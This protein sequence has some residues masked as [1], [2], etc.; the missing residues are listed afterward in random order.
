MEGNLLNEEFFKHVVM[1]QVNLVLNGLV[2]NLKKDLSENYY[3]DDRLLSR[4]EVAKKLD[5]SIGTIDNLR[6]RGKLKCCTVGKSVKF[7][8]SDVVEYI[9]NLK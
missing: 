7:R 2:E 4:E 5:V 9:K 1:S 6:K 3:F 8:N